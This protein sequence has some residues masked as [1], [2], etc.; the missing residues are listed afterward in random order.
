MKAMSIK[1]IIENKRKSAIG[2][3]LSCQFIEESMKLNISENNGYEAI[4]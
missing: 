2:C 4:I 3:Q 1:N